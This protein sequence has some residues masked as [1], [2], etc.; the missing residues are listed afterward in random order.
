MSYSHYD[1]LTALD[2]SFLGIEDHSCHMHVGSVG[3]FDAGPLRSRDGDLDMDRIM[4][5]ADAILARHPRFRQKLAYVP[6]LGSPVWVDDARF[7]LSYHVRHA[8]LPPPGTD[9]QLKRLAGRIMSQQLDRGKPLWELWY[10]EGLR[11]DRFAVIAKIHHCMVDG[12]AGTDLMASMMGPD[13]H[14][15]PSSKGS[16]WMPRPAPSALQL[17][18]DETLRRAGLPLDVARAAGTLV[19]HPR[20]ALGTLR[21]ALGSVGEVLL[22]SASSA[23]PTPLNCD[24][25]PHRR[26]D[27]V[28]LDL[29]VVKSIK[30]HLGATVN[31]VVLAIVAGALRRFLAQ[32][33]ESV[34]DLTFRAMI[35]V[36]MRQTSEHAQLGNRVSLMV[37]ALPLAEP[38]PVRRLQHVVETMRTL[39]GSNQRHGTELLA[40]V[41]DRLSGS[42]LTQF[43]RLTSRALPY[44]IVVTNVP[45]PPFPVYTLGA[46]LREVYPLVPLFANQGLGIA[47]FSYDG[48]L[49]WGFNADWDALPDLHDLVDAVA[50]ECE[51]LRRAAVP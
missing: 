16:K 29:D 31:D 17:L 4:A 8:A 21:D 41:S 36:N 20:R 45:G 47:L 9:R 2:A 28:R 43:A 42:L 32:R 13:P 35:P 34:D 44:N 3:I 10:I 48:G 33:G 7:N 15:V 11:D 5:M 23:T 50:A 30:N 12:V 19:A 25:G 27:W 6:L 40:E 22:A 26:F 1:R 51:T 37:A 38:D 46:P 14:H 18:T 49:Y 24:I 39:K